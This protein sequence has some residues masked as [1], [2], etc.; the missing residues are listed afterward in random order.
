MLPNVKQRLE[1]C[2]SLPSVPALAMKVLELCQKEDLNFAEIAR[3]ISTDPALATKVLRMANSPVMGL[4]NPAK[5]VSHALALLGINAVRTLALSFSLVSDLRGKDKANGYK[6]YWKRSITAG[7]AAQELASSIKLPHAEEAFLSSLL[8]DIGMLALAQ[9]MPD[10]Y[11][12]IIVQAAGDHRKLI[13]GERAELG[14]DHA[15]VGQWLL[16][17]WK[18]PGALSQIVGAS[19]GDFS[20]CTDPESR[21]FASVVALS[22]LVADIWVS[23]DAGSATELAQA[24]AEALLG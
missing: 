3:T 24:Q 23:G 2:T 22:G 12:E 14:C 7:I 18:L 4:R 15:D 20:S 13:E 17:R 10:V 1:R 5:T 16:T 21:Q 8:Q 19:H 11:P 6:Q 9:G